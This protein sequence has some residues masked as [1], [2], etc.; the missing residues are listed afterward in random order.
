[1]IGAMEAIAR[2]DIPLY[3]IGLVPATDNRP[4]EDAYVPGD[5]LRMHSGM[6]VEVL[7]TDAE[8][9]LILA[10]VLSYAKLYR[11]EIVIDLATLTGAQVVA[12][13]SQV[14]AVMTQQDE[15]ADERLDTMMTVGNRTGDLL[16]PM[17]MH[18]HY[19]DALKSEVADIKNIG[20]REAG[21][22]TA[23][24]FLERFVDYPWVHVDI[25]GP[26]FLKKSLPYK[27][28]GGT[29]F[30]VR[31]LTEFVRDYAYPKKR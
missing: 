26:A 28:A 24:K 19:A 4:G 27:P 9:R 17:P 12:L 13:G 15:D 2:L 23:A 18:A 7:N 29:G 20:D 31:L 30:G 21:S 5:V 1:M 16:H 25:A 14:A 11:P 8:G 3:V 22:I 6:T 10:D